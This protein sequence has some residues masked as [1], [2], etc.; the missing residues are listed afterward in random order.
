MNT[1]EHAWEVPVG[2]AGDQ[3]KRHPALRGLDLS[4]VGGRGGPL[5]RAVMMVTKSLLF[6]TEGANGPPVLNAHNKANGQKLGSIE[7]PAPGMYGMMT[8]MHEGRQYIVVQ[9]AKGGEFAG[10]L[11][12]L[13]LPD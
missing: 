11:A 13:R 1:G 6:A 4:G 10:S 9:I 8:Y 3:L 7:L 5:S 2:E 12:A